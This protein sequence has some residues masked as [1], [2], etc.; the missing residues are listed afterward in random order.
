MFAANDDIL[1]VEAVGKLNVYQ[2]LQFIS[3]RIDKQDRIKRA[4]EKAV[5]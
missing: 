3:Y 4:N 5:G 2:V 1:N